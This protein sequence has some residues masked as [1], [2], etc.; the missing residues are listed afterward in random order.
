MAKA[1]TTP[2]AEL[3]EYAPRIETFKIA[4]ARSVK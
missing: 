1:L 2:A 4:T 3:G